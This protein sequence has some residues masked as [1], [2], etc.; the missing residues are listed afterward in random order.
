MS[1]ED[2]PMEQDEVR[3]LD[4]ARSRAAE[5]VKLPAIFLIVIGVLNAL[6]GLYQ[7]GQGAY[8]ALA[9]DKGAE[10]QE[11]EKEIQ[12]NTGLSKEQRD[13]IQNIAGKIADVGPVTGIILGLVELLAAAATIFG[14]VQMMSLR[15]RGLAILGSILAMI[16]CVSIMG[17]CGLGEGVGIW[18]LIVLMSADVKS[19]FR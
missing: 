15:S 12:K 10:K 18:S 4:A 5:K 13:Q 8:Q 16:P 3:G 19:A 17:C 2:Q 11:V 6:Y 9:K 14:G 7:T 1:Y